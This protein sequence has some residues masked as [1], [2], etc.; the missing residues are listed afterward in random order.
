MANEILAT[1][2]GAHP[3]PEW[4]RPDA[5]EQTL[6]DAVA[7]ILKTQEIL[8][9][10]VLVDGEFNRFIP[11]H[12]ETDGKIDYFVS[13]LKNIRTE[14]SR[15][16]GKLF[17]EL[18]H[19]RFR[20]QPAGVV[21]G[22][23]GDGTL[24][25]QR[26]FQRARPLT[27]RPLKFTLTSPYMLARVLVDRHYHSREEL[28][29]ALADVL[30]GQIRDL[31]ADVIQINEEVLTGNPSDG[32]WVAEALNR[33]F[34]VVRHKSCLHL[35]FGNYGGQVVQTQ[36]RYEQLIDFINLLHVDHVLLE[37]ARRGPEELAAIK[38]I[39]PDIGIGLGVVD[40]KATQIESPEYIARQIET[41]EK[42]L[43]PGRIKYVTPDCGLWMQ[44]RSV[45]DG[46]MAALVRG[47]DLFLAERK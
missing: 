30:A 3:V 19:L 37:M 20:N 8:G 9:L 18:P 28:V 29:N 34:G 11:Q 27:T 5:G 44:R 2:V 47:R 15:S 17:E 43:G 32:P 42:A 4:F 24:N 21:E 6:R 26:D 46:K 10:D 16:E 25:L 38:D 31:D 7:V 45:A 1:L 23:I 14:L 33:I 12:P 39:K 36:G 35:C 41:A 40:V 13:Q 22:Q